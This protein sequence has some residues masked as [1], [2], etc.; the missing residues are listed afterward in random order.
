MWIKANEKVNTASHS[1]KKGSVVNMRG[2]DAQK[3]ID[4]EQAVKANA[5]EI[6]TAE[7][8]LEKSK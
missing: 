2:A 6:K 4:K 1:L 5:K 8:A 3:L 7:D